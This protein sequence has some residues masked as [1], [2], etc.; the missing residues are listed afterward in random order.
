MRGMQ[1]SES[2]FHL[3]IWLFFII[4]V[5]LFLERSKQVNGS[6]PLYDLALSYMASS[7][8]PISGGRHKVIK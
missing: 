8:D 2:F 5:H 4:E 1:F 7:E 3:L 6:T